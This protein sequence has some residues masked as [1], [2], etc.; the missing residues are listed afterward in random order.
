MG[1][2]EA[3]THHLCMVTMPVGSVPEMLEHA[4]TALLVAPGDLSGLESVLQK[5]ALLFAL[6]E[7]ARDASWRY[8]I[9]GVVARLS[10]IYEHVIKGRAPHVGV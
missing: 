3:M 10:S 6:A 7:A 4:R 1:V 2:F 9:G 5:P 8:E